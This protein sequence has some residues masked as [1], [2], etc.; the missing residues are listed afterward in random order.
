V[1]RLISKRVEE[2]L[3]TLSHLTS[4]SDNLVVVSIESA[5]LNYKYAWNGLAYAKLMIN[6]EMT[7]EGRSKS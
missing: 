7:A 3:G 5:S 6:T 1:G 2:Y 4:E